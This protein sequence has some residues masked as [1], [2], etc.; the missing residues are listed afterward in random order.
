[1]TALRAK[2]ESEKGESEKGESEKGRIYFC[3]YSGAIALEK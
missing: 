1:L 3:I 2:K